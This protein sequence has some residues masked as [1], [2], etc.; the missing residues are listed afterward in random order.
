MTDLFNINAVTSGVFMVSTNH[1]YFNH[2][3]ELSTSLNPKP[4]KP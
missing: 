1:R 3:T 4:L 2:A